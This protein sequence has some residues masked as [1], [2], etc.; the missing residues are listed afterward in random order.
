[1][2][3]KFTIG[4]MSKLYGL[5]E[6]TLRYYD[7]I[8]LFKPVN[9]NDANGY[10]YY[11]TEQFEQLNIIQ[12]LKYLGVP[13]KEIRTHFDKRDDD[14]LLHLLMHCKEVSEKKLEDLIIIQNRFNHRI[15]EL[16]KTQALQEIGVAK[17]KKLPPRDI[18]CIKNQI[19]NRPELE[20]SLKRL[21]RSTHI[22]S[23]LFIGRIG[24]SI[25]RNDLETHNFGKY[26]SI[27]I[28]PEETVDSE[29]SLRKLAAGEYACIYCRNTLFKTTEYYERLI[30]FI[31]ARGYVI[32]GESVERTIIDQFISGNQQKHL[33]EIQ[34]PVKKLD[35]AN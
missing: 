29:Q 21:E 16:Q 4:E 27:F 14:Y 9:V 18:L 30:D 8:G 28:F 33:S 2:Q 34:I 10:R 25:A 31:N 6:P 11:S 12:Y 3:N 35:T 17:I 15:D 20:I 32:A 13:L 22:K 23:S 26:S 7:K 19:R 24:V 1:M 5:P